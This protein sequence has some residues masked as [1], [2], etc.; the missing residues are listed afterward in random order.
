MNFSESIAQNEENWKAFYMSANP[1]EMS[2]P[3]PY[4]SVSE[5]LKLVIFKCIRPDAVHAAI[6]K[7]ICSFDE[8]FIDSEQVNLKSAFEC[9]TSKT[10]LIYFTS[11]G[12][13]AT[14][15]ILNLAHEIN[16]GEK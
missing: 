10:P 7:F 8:T 13:D 15:D 11:T 6:E 14:A 1:V 5:L 16:A 2:L 3:A 9:S 12:I 4:G